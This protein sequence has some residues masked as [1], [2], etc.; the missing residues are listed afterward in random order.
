MKS[1][2]MN[3]ETPISTATAQFIAEAQTR[4]YDDEIVD[5]AKR[6][7][8]DWTGVAIGAQDQ[9][10]AE[11]MPNASDVLGAAGRSPVIM[12]DMCIARQCRTHQWCVVSR[13]GFR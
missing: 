11:V 2:I 10:L 7:L 4:T 13:V 8:V 5:L 6:C 1:K 9:P 3:N 12:G